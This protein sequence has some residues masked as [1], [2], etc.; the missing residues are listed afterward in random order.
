[1]STSFEKEIYDYELDAD[2]SFEKLEKGKP[3]EDE[4]AILIRKSIE[5][6]NSA[7]EKLV[8]R[9]E[10]RVYHLI[11]NILEN[12]EDAEDLLQE[13]FL[14]VYRFL[15]QFRGE[16]KFITYLYRIAINLCF[17][18]LKKKK[19]SYSLD[20]LLE[21]NLDDDMVELL[22]M[23]LGNPEEILLKKELGLII[24][25]SIQELP[26]KFRVVFFLRE[27]ENF[28][29]KQVSEILGYSIGTIKSQIHR[30]RRFLHKKI[31]PYL[32]I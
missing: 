16:A 31:L 17:Q 23:K 7:F 21:A 32:T 4:D 20:N 18:K 2:N 19:T 27:I 14:K 10:S 11:Y 26:E 29:N 9:Y 22:S 1:M 28:S 8:G 5:G 24:N 6:D 15:S 13:T 3:T 30:I 25:E 12:K